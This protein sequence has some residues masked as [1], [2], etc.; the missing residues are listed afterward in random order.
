MSRAR[1]KIMLR[2]FREVEKKRKCNRSKD[3]QDD[4]HLI[5]EEENDLDLSICEVQTLLR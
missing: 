5:E 3:Q 4:A 2:A 1:V